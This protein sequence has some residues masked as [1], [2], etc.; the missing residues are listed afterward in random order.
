[1]NIPVALNSQEWYRVR[2]G[3]DELA[4][5][6]G[7]VLPGLPEVLCSRRAALEF[8]FLEPEQ[9][10]AVQAALRQTGR[11]EP[12]GIPVQHG[13]GRRLLEVGTLRLVFGIETDTGR[14][15]LSTIRGGPVLDP[16]NHGPPP[17]TP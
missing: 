10:T 17:E 2:R 14:A 4:W 5:G 15:L 12:P 3:E 11:T 1:M 8:A 13:G 7:Q 16:E 9:Q 6:Q